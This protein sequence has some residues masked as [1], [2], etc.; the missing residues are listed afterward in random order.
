M[1]PLLALLASVALPAPSLA[2]TWEYT[3]PR[4][5]P[6]RAASESPLECHA[7]TF[8][9]VDAQRTYNRIGTPELR[10]GR[11]FGVRARVDPERPSL[12]VEQRSDRVAG[13]DVVQ[14]VYR[15]HFEKIPL[16]FSRYFFEAHRN[17]GLMVVL[18]QDA[19]TRQLL[20]VSTVHTCGCYFVVVPTDAV[21]PDWLPEGWTSEQVLYGQRLP[22]TLPAA[23]VARGVTVALESQSHR[24]TGIEVG[25]AG[26][27]R[28]MPIELVPMARLE[29]L[30]IEG[31][32]GETASFFYEAG[33]LR[34]HVRGAWNPMEGLTVFGWISLDPTVGMDKQFGDP[35]RTGTPFYTLLP[36]WLHQRSRLDR[37]DSLLRAL[38][39]RLPEE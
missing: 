32:A 33:P 22:G 12:F 6:G 20:F 31:R 27:G 16:R 5:E 38:D 8:R 21:D 29:A 24:V 10:R 39:F 4:C 26:E 35:E 36:F 30:P 9:V 17:P 18:T 15:I 11:L 28:S 14:L 1:A 25:G 3:P 37:F 13:R 2:D 34:G 7:P 23:E 19:A